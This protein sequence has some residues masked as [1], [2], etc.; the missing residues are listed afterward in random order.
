M[1]K[2]YLLV[3]TVSMFLA[4]TSC[5]DDSSPTPTPEIEK[6]KEK[7]EPE[8]SIIEKLSQEWVLR[9]T[10]ENDVQKTTDGEG[11]YLFTAEGA[12]FAK[13]QGNW[14][15]IGTYEF[16]NSDSSTIAVLF[17]STTTPVDMDIQTLTETELKT[18]FVTNGK[19]FRYNYYR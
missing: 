12:F 14:E 3:V 19:T 11:E 6:E 7:E 10:F 1:K 2:F 9:E 17:T 16:T 5:S 15:A 18:E 4:M 8:L 13:L